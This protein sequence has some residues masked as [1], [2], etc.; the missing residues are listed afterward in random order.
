MSL[1]HMK[2]LPVE[3]PFVYISGGLP[4]HLSDWAA[5]AGIRLRSPDGKAVYS[6][7]FD[8]NRLQ[9]NW[10]GQQNFSP[11]SVQ[12]PHQ[13]RISSGNL[14]IKALGKR[15]RVVADLSAGMGVDAF[16]IASTGRKVYCIERCPPVA[17]LLFDGI[18]RC[19]PGLAD[20]ICMHYC[21]SRLWLT[22]QSG[23]LDVI[24][25]D[26]MFREKKKSVKSSK[27]MQIL[28]ELAGEDLDAQSLIDCALSQAV[29]RVIVKKSAN[30]AQP[31]TPAIVQYRGKTIRF[32]VFKPQR[33]S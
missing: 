31:A 7:S 20:L 1:N 28:R 21:D 6:L 12:P 13:N 33:P 17:M 23:N 4:V 3:Q 18:S 16:T 24:Y 26:T 2:P 22:Q 14:L 32:D 29:S 25:I 8:N 9:L 19:P 30:A 27:Q 11:V 10:L 15:A 5:E